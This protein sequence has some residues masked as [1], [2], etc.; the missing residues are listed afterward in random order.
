MSSGHAVCPVETGAAPER[1]IQTMLHEWAYAIAYRTSDERSLALPAW[2]RYYNQERQHM[3]STIAHQ[4]LAGART[5]NNPR[6][7]DI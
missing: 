5:V 6:S 1:F 4:T 7:L 3:L 2:L